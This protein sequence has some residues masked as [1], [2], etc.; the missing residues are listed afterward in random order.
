VSYFEPVSVL[1]Y[2]V[3][4]EYSLHTDAFDEKRI[5]D[6]ENTGDFGGQRIT[7]N[8]VYLLPAIEGGQTVYVT[9]NV[10]LTGKT[11]MAIIH[12]NSKANFEADNKSKHI[13]KPIITGEKWLLRNAVRQQPLFGN[14]KTPLTAD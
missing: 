6:H 7:T 5:K 1:K 8:L 11:G 13:G 4:D 14:N 2:S 3:G 9:P 10:T 12:S